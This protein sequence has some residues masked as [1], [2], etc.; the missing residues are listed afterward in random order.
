LFKKA[1]V[2]TLLLLSTSFASGEPVNITSDRIEGNVNRTVYASGNV[3][4]T[5]RSVRIKGE[6]AS[7]NRVDNIIKVEGNVTIEE[8]ETLLRCSEIV[9]DLN[10]KRAF[11][12]DV[13]GRLTETDYIKAER[14]DRLSEKE[15]IAYNGIYTPCS[16]RCPDWS[17]GAKRFRI[18]LGESFEGK[19][20]TFRVKEIP[21]AA[22]P[23]ISGSLVKRRKSGFLIPRVG[24]RSD[25]GFIYRQPFYLVLGRSADATFTY[26]KRFKGGEG[27]R[28]EFRYVTAPYSSG[29]FRFYHF[30]RRGEANRWKLRFHQYYWPSDFSYGDVDIEAVSNRQYYKDVDVFDIESKT[31]KYTKSDATYS[32]LWKHAILNAN[33][34]YLD[35]LDGSTDYVFQRVPNVNFYLMDIPVPKTPL[36]FNLDSN[37]TYFYRRKGY[38]GARLNFQPGLRY[39]KSI[40][41]VRNTTTVKYLLTYYN[42]SLNGTSPSSRSILSLENRSFMNIY[43]SFGK[44]L[45]L[46]LNPE[47]AF[48]F[49]ENENQEGNPN[50]DVTDR[51]GKQKSLIP[52][53]TSYIYL[54][55]RQ[56]ARISLEGNYNFYNSDNPWEIWK[57]DVDTNPFKDTFIRETLYYSPHEREVKNINSYV[58]TVFR[59]V[60]FWVNHYYDFTDVL[61]SNYLRWGFGFPIGRFFRFSFEQRYDIELSHDRERIYR[62]S[63]DRGCWSGLITYRWL[64]NFDNTV[65]YQVMV[66]VNLL[67]IGSYGYKLQGRIGKR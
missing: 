17:V 44:S 36:T 30:K 10:R 39:S 5:F 15:W 11:L 2:I 35:R 48:K 50:Y 19:W 65:D 21:V 49:T 13:D 18:L 3:T 64:K 1:A 16:H 22:S 57:L 59:G 46:S 60:S 32:K 67:K 55:S 29:E 12:K 54:K 51:I 37:L 41:K 56:L 31:S 45:S 34:V 14:I 42:R 33:V 40:G 52:S 62:L 53:L 6:R 66:N 38:R 4:I 24:Y 9:Y 43:Y 8:G 28:V 20:V 47:V 63:V 23:Y 25:D 26:E 58:S 61:N 27:K 7:F